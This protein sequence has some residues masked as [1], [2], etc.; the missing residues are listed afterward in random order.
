MVPALLPLD[1]YRQ[2]RAQHPERDQLTAADEELVRLGLLLQRRAEL[3]LSSEHAEDL[4]ELTV[5]SF[6]LADVVLALGGRRRPAAPPGGE[7][8]SIDQRLSAHVR[9]AADVAQ[10]GGAS[11]LASAL[12]SLVEPS[13]PG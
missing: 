11:A 8:V 2:D 4:E 10:Q 3:P 1:A 12:I 7:N 9:E 13:P 5:A 6:A